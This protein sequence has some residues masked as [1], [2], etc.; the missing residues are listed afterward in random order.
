MARRSAL[1]A[2]VV[3]ALSIPANAQPRDDVRVRLSSFSPWAA[4]D[5]PLSLGI[6][7][8]NSGSTPLEDVVVRLTIRERVRNRSSLRASLDGSASG[9]VLAETTEEFDRPVGAGET[10][11]IP[12]QRDLGSLATAFRAGRA[13]DGVYPLGIRVQARGRRVDRAGAIVFLATSPQQSLNVVWVMP[14]HRPFA[15]DARGTYDRTTL[16]RELLDTSRIRAI[17]DLLARHPTVPLTLAPTG[18]VGD[19]LLD[20][21]NGFTARG[22]GRGTSVPATDPLARSAGDVLARLGAAIA[23]PTY[24]VATSTYARTSLPRLAASGLTLDAGRQLRV[25]QQRVEAV[26]ARKPNP[27]L[28]V[29]GLLTADTRSVRTI[30]SLGG[31]TLVLDPDALRDAPQGPFGPDQIQEV[32]SSSLSFDALLVDAPIRERLQLPSEDPVLTAMGT[33]AETAASYFERP[34]LSAGRLLVVSTPGMPEPAVAAPLLDALAQAPWLRIRTASD[35]AADPG[36][37]NPV[38]EPRRLDVARAETSPRV[39]QARAA[40]EAIDKLERILVRPS[41]AE[42][43]ASLEQLLLVS[44]SADYDRRTGTAVGLA[45]AVR[46]RT[47]ELLKKIAVP[48]RRVTLTRQ[49]GQVPV[50]IQNRTGHTIRLRVE[51]ESPRVTFPGGAARQIQVEGRARGTSL[52]TLTFRIE[53]RT[54]GSFPITV[55]VETPD[56]RDL[57]RTGQVQVRS[58]AVSAVTLMATAGGALFLVGAWARRALSRRPKPD[59]SA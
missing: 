50:T 16:A 52:E 30:A 39:G 11:T 2:A 8:S 1:L 26:L 53:A 42:D 18:L 59:A 47:E 41:G 15:G 46:D 25:G 22:D 27:S 55:R 24:E 48:P 54:A 9:D 37:R 7:I 4:P 44:E 5:R 31:K 13:V 33:V 49:G 56:G 10:V 17:A 36:L 40:R 32:R 6:E 43:V 35:A 29:D 28:F 14:I 45:R 38:D 58:S 19:Q 12:I 3:F 57:I 34:A 21:S 51:L 20:V 23:S